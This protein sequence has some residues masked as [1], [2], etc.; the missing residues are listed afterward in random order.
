MFTVVS[1]RVVKW[2]MINT[3]KACE[4]FDAKSHQYI[5]FWII[6]NCFLCQSLAYNNLLRLRSKFNITISYHDKTISILHLSIFFK[7]FYQSKRAF[8]H[9]I[10]LHSSS[11]FTK[12]FNPK[13]EEYWHILYFIPSL[14]LVRTNHRSETCTLRV[15]HVIGPVQTLNSIVALSPFTPVL[16][17]A[18]TRR[19]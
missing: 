12:L 10:N 3:R 9:V 11:M 18:I 15:L 16:A 6:S 14:E 8:A 7:N 1:I 4:K 17:R 13:L 5:D 19:A 2:E